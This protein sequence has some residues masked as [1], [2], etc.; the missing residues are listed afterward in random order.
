[1]PCTPAATVD[2]VQTMPTLIGL[3]TTLQHS[4]NNE[5]PPL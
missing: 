2:P 4:L 1:L 3:N 5:V